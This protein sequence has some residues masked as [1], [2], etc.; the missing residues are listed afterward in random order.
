MAGLIILGTAS[1]AGKSAVV[2][3]LLRIYA[4]RGLKVAPFKAQN[5]ALNSGVTRDGA[6]IGRAQL[7][8][9]EAARIEA[10]ARMNPVLLKPT[11]EG[12]SQVVVEGRVYK[13]LTTREY[14][15]ETPDLLKKAIESYRSLEREYDLVIAEGAGSA[16]E[17]NLKDVDIVNMGFAKKAEIPAILVADIDR[18][19][20]FGSVVG[21]YELFDAKERA[22]FKGTIVN[23]FRGDVSLLDPGLRELEKR[24]ERPVLGVIPYIDVQLDP[25]D[26]LSN[27][28]EKKRVGAIDIAIVRFPHL[29]N[30]TDFAPFERYG[31]VSVRTIERVE[32][33]GD[34][35]LLFLPGT[36]NTM[37]DLT[38][39]KESGLYAR[40]LR[41]AAR[42]KYLF[43]LCG[44]FQMLG[45]TLADPLG[46]ERFGE[47]DGLNLIPM[48]TEMTERKEQRRVKTSLQSGGELLRSAEG[49]AV[50][51]YELHMGRS[52]FHKEMEILTEMGGVVREGHI[53]GTYL[54]GFFDASGI[55]DAVVECLRSMKHVSKISSE[56]E[57]L[58]YDLFKERQYDKLADAV[59]SSLDMKALD[60]ILGLN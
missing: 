26:S 42:G 39:L 11:G 20:M 23:K 58:S 47:V 24:I 16:S 1:N 17:I 43:G 32:D 21:T 56:D 35:D 15:K 38:W 3:A 9:A 2:A 41:H 54:H 22:L 14:Y 28:S 31:D 53:Y 46:V 18:G 5:M 25:E 8:Q 27:L 7:M 30:M 50:E 34:P 36:K 44:G 6:E 29:S 33:F 55:A 10:D 57:T 19:G 4:D 51:G 40:V 45:S 59:A 49:L 13:N 60:G 12:V 48:A 52:V 37:E